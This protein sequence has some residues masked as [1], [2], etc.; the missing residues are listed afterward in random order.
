[1]CVSGPLHAGMS[2]MK[3][4]TEEI[5]SIEF[6]FLVAHISSFIRNLK[7][8]HSGTI[9]GR[10]VCGNASFEDTFPHF[11]W[12]FLFYP[13]LLWTKQKAPSRKFRI[14]FRFGRMRGYRGPFRI[15]PRR[16]AE[17][18]CLHETCTSDLG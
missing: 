11:S 4:E 5:F 10:R 7:W 3:F 17:K 6:N 14:A 13:Y 2:M 9:L 16:A 15:H 8:L 1:M 18:L 12:I